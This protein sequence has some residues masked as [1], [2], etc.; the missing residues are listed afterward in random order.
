MSAEISSPQ[1][2]QTLR[3][4]VGMASAYVLD[5]AREIAAEVARPVMLIASRRQVD[6]ARLGGGYVG[7]TTAEWCARARPD[8]GHAP[9]FLCRDHGGPYQHPDEA[10]KPTDP[11]TAMRSSLE[12]LRCDIESGIKLLHID[13][14]LGPGGMAEL[15]HVAKERAIEL[16]GA[17]ADLAR[18]RGRPVGFEIGL[19]V[20]A[21][22]IANYHEYREWIGDLLTQLRQRCGLSPTFVVAQ[23]GTKV[24]GL[25]NTG[26]IERQRGH[27]GNQQRLRDLASVARSLGSRLKAHNCDYLSDKAVRQM[28]LAGAWMNISPEAGTAQTIAIVRAARAARVNGPLDEFCDAAISAGY[29]RKWALHS[30]KPISDDEKVALGGS[31]LF[32]TP[33]FENLRERIDGALRPRGSSTRRIAIEA[34]KAVMYRYC[35]P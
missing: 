18:S 34:V 12:S 21:E 3:V 7:W 22:D 17:S 5:A 8:D 13:T 24:T 6:S 33:A 30:E 1:V 4:A 27:P 15:P 14:S 16:V 31:Y 28:R 23:T 35:R 9:L 19:E 20:Q 11:A 2:D 26:V 10:D 29:W 25:H 32:A